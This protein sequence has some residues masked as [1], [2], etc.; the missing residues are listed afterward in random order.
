MSF[1]FK[2]LLSLCLLPAMAMGTFAACTAE[3]APTT[4]PVPTEPA[5]EA[6]VLKLITLGSSSTVDSCHLLNLV[7]GTEDIGDY[8]EVVVGTLYY[9]GCKLS[10]HV[11]FMTENAPKYSLYLS[12][13]KT[14]DAPPA[15]MK[16]VTMEAALK[17]D[18]WDII[19]M[20]A[21]GG[22]CDSDETLT[23]GNI[24]LIQNYVREKKLNPLAPFGWHFTCI[25]PADPDLTAMYP[26]TPNPY[27][28]VNEKYNFDREACFAARA[29]RVE[30]IIFTD[31]SFDLKI[32]SITAVQNAATSY[33]TEKDLYRDYTHSTDLARVMTAYVWYCRLMGIEKLE[34]VKLDAIPKQFLKS[35]ADKTQDRVLTEAEKAIILE[36]VNNALANPMKITQSRYTEAPAN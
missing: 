20:Q 8:E 17:F 1:I 30:R 19:F 29:G 9:S 31:E 16:E 36:S 28:K 6:K 18:Y 24:Q 23:N 3:P 27:Q 34:K 10:Q 26:Y 33:L 14:P 12:S 7:L 32:C 2:K 22:E 15:I 35:T 5:A 13:S 21:N 4:E 11:Q 25:S